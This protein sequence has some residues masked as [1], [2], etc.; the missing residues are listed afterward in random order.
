M[1]TAFESLYKAGVEAIRYNG[2]LIAWQREMHDLGFPKAYNGPVM[3]A[4]FDIVADML[5]GMQ[6]T[7]MD[8]YRQ[9]V[10]KNRK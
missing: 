2:E 8:M 5:R 3:F 9:P 1:V 4:P 10:T 7:M 6:G